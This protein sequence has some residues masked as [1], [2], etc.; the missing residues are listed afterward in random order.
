M[1]LKM[2]TVFIMMVV[3]TLMAVNGKSEKPVG[4][5][6]DESDDDALPELIGPSLLCYNADN[7]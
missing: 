6:N 5:V 1:G 2:L 4:V 7:D 3:Q